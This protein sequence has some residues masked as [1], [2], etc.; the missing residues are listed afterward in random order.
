MTLPIETDGASRRF[1]KTV[2]VDS[3]SL[4]VDEGETL[5][6]VGPDGAGKTTVLRLLAGVLAPTAGR[7]SVAGFDT[8]RQAE[9]I[10]PWV[11]YMPQRFSLYGDLTVAENLDFFASIFGVSRGSRVRLFDQLLELTG[12][13][14]FRDRRAAHLSGGMQKKLGLACTLVHQPKILLLDEP[15]T[16]VDPVS[17]REFWDMLSGL[18]VQGLTLVV[19][20]PYMDE[21]ERCTSVGLVYQGRLIVHDTPERIRGMVTGEVVEV[22]PVADTAA[23][24]ASLRRAQELVGRLEGV[25][26]LQSYGE[27][28]HVIVDSAARRMPEISQALARSGLGVEGLRQTRPGLEEA[29]IS[30]VRRQIAPRDARSE[31][32]AVLR[33]GCGQ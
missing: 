6:L 16:G 15:T 24:G 22:R 5:G 21:A 17:R 31:G 14:E 4:R 29:F 23:P 12:L 20:T 18:R 7:V 2:A 1:G 9:R 26:E 13:R 30:L 11:G 8:R 10:R 19:A 25:L 33:G 3:L 28:L 32:E 27:T